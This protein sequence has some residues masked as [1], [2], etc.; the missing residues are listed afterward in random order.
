MAVLRVGRVKEAPIRADGKCPQA[1]GRAYPTNRRGS[2]A[3]GE[4][5]SS[6]WLAHFGGQI[7][8]RIARGT[9][10]AQDAR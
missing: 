6:V 4:Y 3:V 10:G 9:Q 5:S 1:V 7:P 2:D 8:T